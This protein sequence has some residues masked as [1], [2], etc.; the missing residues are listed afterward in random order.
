[1]TH[2]RTPPTA[3]SQAEVTSANRGK[4]PT[5]VF[6]GV[7]HRVQVKVFDWSGTRWSDN[8]TNFS[9]RVLPLSADKSTSFSSGKKLYHGAHFSIVWRLVQR[10]VGEQPTP[11]GLA[12]YET[13]DRGGS[14]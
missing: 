2:P 1:M 7:T 5:F 11:A 13:M 6:H 12:K 3:N 10:V 9:V 8:P 4:I 14:T